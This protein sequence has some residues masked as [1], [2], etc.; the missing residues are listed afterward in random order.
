MTENDILVVCEDYTEM[1]FEWARFRRAFFDEHFVKYLGKHPD[2]SFTL[3][4]GSQI[5]F[6]L[7]SKLIHK[8]AGFP[9][10]TTRPS[11]LHNVIRR[12]YICEKRD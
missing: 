1:Q 11:E 8:R 2:Y 5:I 3:Y 9:G 10:L 4:D 6:V 7:R 12:R